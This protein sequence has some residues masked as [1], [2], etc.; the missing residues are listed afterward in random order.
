MAANK[1]FLVFIRHVGCADGDEDGTRGEDLLRSEVPPFFRTVRKVTF[2]SYALF[3]SH[4]RPRHR[5]IGRLWSP[6][7]VPL[8]RR[9]FDGSLT[10]AYHVAAGAIGGPGDRAPTVD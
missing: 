1:W 4:R 9:A 3:D 8:A 6:S 7:L 2:G 10:V 5:E